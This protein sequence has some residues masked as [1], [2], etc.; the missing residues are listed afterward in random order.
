MSLTATGEPHSAAE[1]TAAPDPLEPLG[2][3]AP[4]SARL[5]MACRRPYG[6]RAAGSFSA[7]ISSSGAPTG[8]A[9]SWPGTRRT[10]AAFS[11]LTTRFT[12]GRC[13]QWD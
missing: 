1:D 4:R 8:S 2:P 12:E 3:G 5:P 10:K 9:A 13:R 6:R 11:I 7:S